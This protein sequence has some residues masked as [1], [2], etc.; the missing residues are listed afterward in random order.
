MK[1][2]CGI[3]GGATKTSC[4]IADENGHVVGLGHS[5]SSN[6]SV[7]GV[8]TMLSSIK[9]AL[10]FAV[11]N[12]GISIKQIDTIFVAI[13]GGGSERRR[14]LIRQSIGELGI[15]NKVYVDSDAVAAFTATTLGR[16]GVVVI[17]G[18]GSIVLGLDENGV[19]HRVGGW[20]YLID[21][22]GSAFYIGREALRYAL[23]AYD[24]RGE[25][26][27]L[28]TYI[29][30]HFNVDSLVDVVDLI[31][32]RKIGVVEIASLAPLV[33]KLWKSG[34]GIAST[35]IRR[36]C[37]ELAHAASTVINRM[38]MKNPLVGVRGGVFEGDADFTKLFFQ[39]LKKKVPRIRRSKSKFKPVLGALL[40]A[41][42]SAERPLN[43]RLILNLS[44]SASKEVYVMEA[45][46]LHG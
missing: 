44:E 19:Y 14:R 24:G 12:A 26:T 9:E 15:S 7:V 22:E 21:D 3:D 25:E 6:V 46:F 18:T 30:K 17:S 13:A 4:L 43:R 38:K 2:F 33:V 40:L 41:Y 35:I 31:S 11:E 36:S 29:P 20:G 39:I 23:M 32:L 5:R 45:V 1:F 10:D 28:V 42:K 8:K 37:Y 27:D 16:P 34:D